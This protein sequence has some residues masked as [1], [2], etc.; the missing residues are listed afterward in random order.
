MS[1]AIGMQKKSQKGFVGDF[2]GSISSG[3]GGILGTA[4][5][6]P[7]GGILGSGL[8][9]ALSPLARTLPFAKG[10]KVPKGSHMMPDG[11]IMKDSDMPKKGKKKGKKAMGMVKGSKEAKMKMMRLRAMR[12]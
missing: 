10:G 12:K 3:L 6:G 5:A 4:V 8:G 7:V 1:R 11:T 2:L 9:S